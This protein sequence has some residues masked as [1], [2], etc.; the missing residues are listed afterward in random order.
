[1]KFIAT[2]LA[3]ASVGVLAG[4][5]SPS[6]VSEPTRFSGHWSVGPAYSWFIPL[7]TNDN[8]DFDPAEVGKPVLDFMHAQSEYPTSHDGPETSVY[9]VVDGNLATSSQFSKRQKLH[10][11]KIISYAPARA[12][13]VVSRKQPQD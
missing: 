1:M 8:W 13:F 12:D 7:G 2:I 5:V 10:V 6:Q 4:C 11:R 9:L 3:I